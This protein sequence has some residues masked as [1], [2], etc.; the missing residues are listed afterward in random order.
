MLSIKFHGQEVEVHYGTAPDQTISRMAI[1]SLIFKNWFN[2]LDKNIGVSSITI[3]Q[4]DFR[5]QTPSSEH[6]LFVRLRAMTAM[7]PR[8]QIVELRGHTVAMM[9]NLLCSESRKSVHTVL[10]RQT[11]VPTGKHGYVE[12]PAGM[13]DNEG[14]PKIAALKELAEELDMS[15]SQSELLDLTATLPMGQDGL[16]LSPGLLDEKCRIYLIERKVT[17]SEL[18]AL[19]DKTT[20]VEG[21]GEFIH[22]MIV[23]V[24]ELTRNTCDMKS[25]LAYSLYLKHMS[26]QWHLA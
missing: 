10:V 25:I 4:V 12:I 26:R 14:T 9:V 5:S 2:G 24:D 8:G 19:Q 7:S 6:V 13:V 23:P 20:G 18:E 16:H 22:L 21:E 17:K 3:T 15:F 11:R 1:E